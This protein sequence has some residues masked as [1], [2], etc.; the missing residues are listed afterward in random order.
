MI[1]IHSSKLKKRN[2]AISLYWAYVYVKIEHKRNHIFSSYSLPGREKAQIQFG[3]QKCY[4][5]SWNR[6]IGI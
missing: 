1:A 6:K 2:I 3:K 5:C 4:E